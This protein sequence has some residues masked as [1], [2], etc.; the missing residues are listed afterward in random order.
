MTA[1]SESSFPQPGSER[2]DAGSIQ[3]DVKS[4]IWSSKI[5]I[6]L[7]AALRP[8]FPPR[9]ATRVSSPE[10]TYFAGF[11]ARVATR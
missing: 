9:G 1:A 3:G 6:W 10:R 4:P 2:T 11:A 5:P 8:P 7:M